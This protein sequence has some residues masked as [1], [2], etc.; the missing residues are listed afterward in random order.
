MSENLMDKA[1]AEAYASCPVDE[2]VILYT[3]EFIHESFEAP[4]R[5]VRWPVTSNEIQREQKVCWNNGL[6]M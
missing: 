6:R 2:A 3:L 4:A 1:I 5:V